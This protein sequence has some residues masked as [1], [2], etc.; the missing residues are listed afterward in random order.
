M[1]S[2]EAHALHATRADQP[3]APQAVAQTQ[4]SNASSLI[5]Y[6]ANGTG[7]HAVSQ[8]ASNNPVESDGLKQAL[9]RE[10][11]Q[12]LEL[13]TKQMQFLKEGGV[14]IRINNT[15]KDMSSDRPYIFQDG[16]PGNYYEMGILP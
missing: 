5:D 12:N 6:F 15:V 11:Q 9:E 4:S 3:S 2:E 10:V 1:K 14:V 13:A 7:N 16:M 8:P